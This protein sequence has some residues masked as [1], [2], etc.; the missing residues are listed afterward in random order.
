M[1]LNRYYYPTKYES[2]NK[3][4]SLGI[5]CVFISHQQKD[6]DAAKKIADYLIEAGI[7]VYFDA[8][9]GDLRIHHQSNNAKAVTD[10]IRKGINNSS[11]MLVLVSPNTLYS[12]WVPFEIGY[13]YDKTEVLTLCLKGITKGTLPEYLKATKIIRDIYD[14]N[15]FCE[16]IT[17]IKKENLIL[18]SKLSDYNSI[19]NP[20][21]NIMDTL[22]N[23]NY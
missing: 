10:S 17:G 21:S 4:L 2:R 18:E 22:I 5:K 8:Y 15:I 16:N 3:V 12:T 11:H 13:G 14:F 7:D 20:L 1:A 23:E 9:D 6:K 19:Y